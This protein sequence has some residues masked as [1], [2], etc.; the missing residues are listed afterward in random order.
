MK[1]LFVH[2]G[3]I[4]KSDL[5]KANQYSL[6]CIWISQIII[7]ISWILEVFH[8]FIVDNRLMNIAFVGVTILFV[9]AHVVKAII[10]FDNQLGSYLTL[11]LLVAIISYANIFLS[12][13]TTM[14]MLFPMVCA[15]LYI[16]KRYT[17]FTFIL[18][19]IGMFLAVVVGFKIGLC[20]ANML[21]LT[22]SDSAYQADLIRRGEVTINEDVLSLVL[23]Y[24]SP[25]LL[26][27]VGFSFLVDYI[28][29]N[30]SERTKREIEIKRVAET[31]G[32]TGLYNRNKYNQMFE[33]PA[34]GTIAAIYV[35]INDLKKTNDSLG[36]EHGDSLILGISMIL[37]QIQSERCRAYRLGGDEFVVIIDNPVKGEA[38]KMVE[39]IKKKIS[40]SKLE[41]GL[42]LSAAIGYAE[43]ARERIAEIMKEADHNMYENKKAIKRSRRQNIGLTK[44]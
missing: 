1:Q 34:T 13:H 40:E 7:T 15:A 33:A 39:T 31:D 29:I 12:Y 2:N 3:T 28:K 9:L 10:G 4:S 42:K 11:F 8:I 25:R 27:L 26:T 17:I 21:I 38:I 35:D 22:V 36:H 24:F 43:G 18:T 37:D 6:R 16:E 20:D 14:F 44:H 23:Y 30:I 32:L 5:Y 41:S 19:A